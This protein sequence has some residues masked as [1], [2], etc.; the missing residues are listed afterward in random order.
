MV[1]RNQSL[2]FPWEPIAFAALSLDPVILWMVGNYTSAQEGGRDGATRL[3][4]DAVSRKSGVR[5]DTDRISFQRPVHQNRRDK[6]F[7]KT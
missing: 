7:T 1:W 2:G 3:N 4:I 6:Q 5:E